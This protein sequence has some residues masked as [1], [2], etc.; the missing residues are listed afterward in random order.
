MV[1]P[2]CRVMI[3][4]PTPIWKP[5]TLAR[6]S[7]ATA[8]CPSS[9][10]VRVSSTIGRKLSAYINV[11]NSSP[12]RVGFSLAILC[13]GFHSPGESGARRAGPSVTAA[14]G[15]PGSPAFGLRQRS[16]PSFPG[17]SC[18]GSGTGSAGR[19]ACCALSDAERLSAFSLASSR[20]SI[21][22]S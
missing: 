17:W 9:W 5:D 16:A 21:R 22:L 15:V 4:H 1:L 12:P 11:V 2:V 3:L 20:A 7:L 13:A 8:R 6:L 18:N 19:H 14:P 10:T